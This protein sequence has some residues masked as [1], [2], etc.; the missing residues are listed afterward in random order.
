MRQLGLTAVQP[1]FIQY[2]SVLQHHH[3]LDVKFL[4]TGILKVCVHSS[5]QRAFGLGAF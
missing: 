1:L 4:F 2:L 5:L 3:T